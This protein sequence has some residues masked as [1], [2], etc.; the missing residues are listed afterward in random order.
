MMKKLLSIVSAFN[1]AICAEHESKKAK[2]TTGHPK[3]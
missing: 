3:K 2:K 1:M